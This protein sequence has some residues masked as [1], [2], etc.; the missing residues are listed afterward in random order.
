MPATNAPCQVAPSQNTAPVLEYRCLYTHDLRRKAKRWQDGHLR[1]HTFN[2]R[3]MVYD[4]L[5]N[6]IAGS[7][8]QPEPGSKATQVEDGDELT[9][10]KNGVMVQVE[11]REGVVHTDLSGL[12]MKRGA[13][14]ASESVGKP[15]GARSVID[16]GAS[17]VSQQSAPRS[18][19]QSTVGQSSALHT[20]RSGPSYT[21]RSQMRHPNPSNGLVEEWEQGPP[22]KRP[23]NDEDHK[24]MWEVL[25]TSR[26][27]KRRQ[28]GVGSTASPLRP[29]S[30]SNVQAPTP[31]PTKQSRLNVAQYVDLLSS[32]ETEGR[33][34]QKPAAAA[35][36]Y[37]N[38]RPNDRVV[39]PG[40][41]I[42][43]ERN[44]VIHEI[45]PRHRRKQNH[46][47]S[48]NF[49]ANHAVIR[50]FGNDITKVS[51]N[52]QENLPN[53]T[54]NA[55]SRADNAI[56]RTKASKPVTPPHRKPPSSPPVSVSN[57][58]SVP[59]QPE[60]STTV[61]D[62]QREKIPP[63]GSS[64]LQA[65]RNPDKPTAK[66]RSDLQDDKM[67]MK[68]LRVASREPRKTLMCST[69]QPAA[70]QRHDQQ[71]ERADDDEVAMVSI[72][73]R[74]RAK[75]CKAT[76]TP[77][78]VHDV[79]E[80]HLAPVPTSP[81]STPAFQT[82]QNPL[83]RPRADFTESMNLSAEDES[84]RASQTKQ[85]RPLGKG[86][87]E[88]VAS[89]AG[90]KQNVESDTM[91]AQGSP[92]EEADVIIQHSLESTSPPLPHEAMDAALLP[93]TATSPPSLRSPSHPTES[94]RSQESASIRSEV[95]TPA[96]SEP[97]AS[98]TTTPAP[99]A[100]S[101]QEQPSLPASTSQPTLLKQGNH[102]P[103]RRHQTVTAAPHAEAPTRNHLYRAETVATPAPESRA[104]TTTG[105]AI[106]A[107]K[108]TH[109][110]A[111]V[112]AAT[113]TADTTGPWSK[114]AWDLFGVGYPGA[115]AGLDGGNWRGWDYTEAAAT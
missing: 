21:G 89:F 65:P 19:A 27:S 38:E 8:W 30:K 35:L 88:P 73:C 22:S 77:D 75:Q 94:A 29:T 40:K 57:H 24:E 26:P 34:R 46:G 25:R 62:R 97:P 68:S 84:A 105:G 10:D 76:S 112:D 103:F 9:L 61:K 79:E 1:F 93:V 106:G 5:R 108:E 98:T 58:L 45:A 60:V 20:A 95:G 53:P 23:R 3:V 101:T 104:T 17:I 100:P 80:E 59:D 81:D 41:V 66:L 52:A 49:E 18:V 12:L 50:P 4:L 2:K 71:I 32:S 110:A 11:E 107:A 36:T 67:P 15:V 28:M 48:I 6:F 82:Q 54:P 56:R 86:A 7:H 109:L 113:R 102:R 64:P 43:N 111:S 55:A 63:S 72:P 37:N 87:V 69:I 90:S 74:K 92:P 99:T 39:T 44:E 14:D 16:R 85:A 78:S 114:E 83:R 51:A 13:Q 115:G 47:E 70:V 42:A 91:S 96:P 33:D 31:K